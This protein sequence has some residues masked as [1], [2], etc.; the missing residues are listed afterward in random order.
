[1]TRAI[2]LVAAL[3]VGAALAGCSK[4]PDTAPSPTGAQ[5]AWT[6]AGVLTYAEAQDP[7]LLNP[8]LAASSPVGDLS[9]LL[10]SYAVRYDDHA[11]PIPDLLTEVPTVANGDVSSD[12]LT[13]RYKI[14]P[15]AKWHDGVAVTSKD[16]W[17]TWQCVMNPHNNVVTTDGYKDIASID[18]RDP[19]VAVIHMRKIYAPY[20]QQIFGVNG[21]AA[22]LPEHLLAKY[23]DDKGSF[24]HAP[25]QSAPVA[26]GPF[27]FVSWQR[28]ASV[29]LEAFPDFYLGRPKL[30]EIVFKILPDEVTMATQV[31][32]H[33]VDLALHGAGAIW[34][35]YQHIPGVIASDPPVYTYDHIDFNLGRP[36]FAHDLMLRRA[37]AIA[38]DR[39]AIVAK[40]LHGLGTPTDTDESPLIGAAYDPNTMHYPF[41]PAK[42]RAMLDADGWKMTASGVRM[43]SGVP[44]HFQISTESESAAFRAME[45]LVQSDWHAVGADVEVKNAPTNLMFDNTSVGILQGGHY[46][47]AIFAWFGAADP[48]DSAVYS[49][50]NFPPRGQNNMQWNSPRATAAMN[51]ALQTLDW[52]RR[53]RDYFIVQE[54]FAK[55]MPSLVIDYR[56]EPIAMNSDLKG[57]A[58]S[59]VISPFWDPWNY[60]I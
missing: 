9:M 7:A 23:N 41:D 53:K 17:F 56:K 1:M 10:F 43:R 3:L 18:Y 47:T 29:R 33:E 37:L 34:P 24:N 21:N 40:V 20:L 46:D 26:S 27:K 51:D 49:A 16:L 13:L 5:N 14:R 28:G 19:H 15:N 54:E 2:S 58:P 30:T 55:D 60:S 11:K 52:P 39:R 38:I 32:T 59:P 31:R 4:V 35:Q 8:M 48:D 25:Y 22:V 44:L 57:F 6:R 36:L 42:A 12:G 50:D 45:V